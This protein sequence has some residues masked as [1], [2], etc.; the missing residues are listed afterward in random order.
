MVKPVIAAWRARSPRLLL[1]WI[2]TAVIC[3]RKSVYDSASVMEIRVSTTT[4]VRPLRRH[5]DDRWR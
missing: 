4:I 2:C 1:A 5:F 3:E